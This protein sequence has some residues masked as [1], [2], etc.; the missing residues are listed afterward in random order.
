MM[1]HTDT[2]QS[3]LDPSVVPGGDTTPSPQPS[4]SST[5]SVQADGPTQLS[6]SPSLDS[7]QA[8][9]A[10]PLLNPAD[11]EDVQVAWGPDPDEHP[12]GCKCKFCQT[13]VKA[14]QSYIGKT[15]TP[16]EQ[17]AMCGTITKTA[18]A[19]MCRLLPELEDRRIKA[20]RNLVFG[21]DGGKLIRPNKGQSDE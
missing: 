13:I 14:L 1:R 16:E 4:T 7:R 19:E 8:V 10:Q 20:E 3:G 6:A 21:P 15:I 2:V 9:Q 18:M 11:F 12:V 17:Q 5:P